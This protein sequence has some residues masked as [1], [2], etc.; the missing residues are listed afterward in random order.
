MLTKDHK[1]ESP[2]EKERIESLGGEVRSKS[3]VY[4]VV[5]KRPVASS[6]QMLFP[7]VLLPINPVPFLAVARSLGD[8]WSYEEEKDEFVVSP[9]P[10]VAVHSFPLGKHGCLIAGSDGLWN[11]IRP[12]ECL[13][14]VEETYRMQELWTWQCLRAGKPEKIHAADV[15]VAELLVRKVL[16]R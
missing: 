3:G 12:N 9:V 1:P 8:F 7:D 2:E 6:T 11:V 10:D 5:W 4:R 13:D 15:N 14:L 16:N